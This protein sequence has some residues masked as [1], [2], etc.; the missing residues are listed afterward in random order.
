[1]KTMV[2]VGKFDNKVVLKFDEPIIT[3][4]LDANNALDIAEEM[5]KVALDLN[6]GIRPANS[7][8]A[9]LAEKSA[10]VLVPRVTLMLS[11][12]EGKPNIY[13]ANQIV[14]SCLSEVL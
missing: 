14:A 12:M 8:K 5:A 3:L 10:S 6:T 11:G 13:K 9:D 2:A 7:L 4:E 1:M